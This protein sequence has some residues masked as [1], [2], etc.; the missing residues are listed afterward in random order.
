V[1][2]R[3]QVRERMP[4]L[5]IG[6][7]SPV[8]AIDAARGAP[9]REWG[10]SLPQPGAILVVSAHWEAAPA[11]LGATARL[12]LIYDFGGF[13]RALYEVQYPAPGAPALAERVRELLGGRVEQDPA[14]GLDHGVWTPL[15]HLYPQAAVPVLQLSLPAA[16]G[17]RAIFELGRRLAP[18]RDEGV[19]LIGSG[20][21]THNLRERL[22]EGA[23]ALDWALA[24]DTWV[25]AS[26]LAR[27]VD[28]LLDYERRAPE[29]RRNHP[30][31]E[32]W[33]PLFVALGAAQLQRDALHFPVTGFEFGTLSRR[34]IQLG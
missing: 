2:E 14:R 6:H 23:P 12:P 33:L 7:G 34:S 18:L 17:A 4:V 3:E 29:L 28:A 9:L 13:P 20:N 5:A 19:L 24:F 10:R 26:L 8:L 15:V 16:L 22:A 27:D 11:L 25:E 31:E 32:H 30:S 21:I 1:T